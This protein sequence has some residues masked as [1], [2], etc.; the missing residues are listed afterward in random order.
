MER[1]RKKDHV[2]GM[3]CRY[4]LSWSSI[5]FVAFKK[6]FYIKTKLTPLNE[7]KKI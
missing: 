7:Y 3:S 4:S 5:K 2:A 1:M 6:W